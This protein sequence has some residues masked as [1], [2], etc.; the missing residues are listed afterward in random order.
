MS[1]EEDFRTALEGA[2]ETLIERDQNTGET[3]FEFGHKRG[4]TL[5]DMLTA[6]DWQNRLDAMREGQG[7]GIPN[8]FKQKCLT[9]G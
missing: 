3:W 9:Q 2:K 4:W 7:A 8:A 1:I 5:A 6:T